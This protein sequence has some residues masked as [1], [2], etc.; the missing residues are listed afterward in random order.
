MNTGTAVKS[1]GGVNIRIHMM[2]VDNRC[3]AGF[4]LSGEEASGAVEGR[5]LLD[6]LGRITD[7]DGDSPLNLLMDRAYEDGEARLLAFEWGYSLEVPPVKGVPE[8]RDE[9]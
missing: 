5:L 4:I 8:D 9:I 1:R 2:V 7:P 3:V 6:T